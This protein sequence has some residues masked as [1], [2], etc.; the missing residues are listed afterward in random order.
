VQ[1]AKQKQKNVWQWDGAQVLLFLLCQHLQFA[2]SKPSGN[3]EQVMD[4]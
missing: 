3:E 4:G 1:K 2:F